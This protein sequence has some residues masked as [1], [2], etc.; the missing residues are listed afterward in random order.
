MHV[1]QGRRKAA[2]YEV[3]DDSTEVFVFAF[4]DAGQEIV[5]DRQAGAG[6]PDAARVVQRR[7]G[8]LFDDVES[9][10]VDYSDFV[11]RIYLAI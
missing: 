5:V 1:A 3:E 9:L 7:S 2:Q 11:E 4:T 10:A 8:P 6:E